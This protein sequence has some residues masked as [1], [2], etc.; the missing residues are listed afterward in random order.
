VCLGAAISM[1]AARGSA[2]WSPSFAIAWYGV[3]G[4]SV[5][6]ALG[7]LAMAAVGESASPTRRLKIV[8]LA[9]PALAAGLVLLWLIAT[10]ASLAD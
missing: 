9:V 3:F 10:V 8:A 7:A 5:V 1:L 4:G 2:D 6:L